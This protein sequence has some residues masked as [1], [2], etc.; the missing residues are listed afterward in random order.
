MTHLIVPIVDADTPLR[1]Q[2]AAAVASGADIVELRVDLIHDTAA[3]ETFLAERQASDPPLILTI[4]SAEEGGGWDGDDA[5]RLALFERLGLRMPGLIDIELATWQRSANLRQKAGLV[6]TRRDQPSGA[7]E[8]D[9]NDLVLSQ[10]DFAGT[11]DD[12]AA[13]LAALL[14]SPATIA[15]AA[16]TPVDATDAVR[17]LAALRDVAP[18]RSVILLGMGLAGVMTRVLGPKFGAWGVFAAQAADR[19]SAPG[20]PTIADMVGQYRFREVNPQTRVFGVIGWPVGHSR[21]PLI[22]NAAMQTLGIDGVYVPLPVRPTYAD[23]ARFLDC[24]SA[25]RWLDLDGVSVTIPHKEHALRWLRET[26]ATVSTL[27]ERCGAVN[28]LVRRDSGWFGENTDALGALDA[29]TAVVDR[30]LAK[31][32]VLV[33]GAGGVARGVVAALA[34]AGAAVTITNR[35][36]ERAAQLASELGGTTCA[37]SARLAAARSADLVV[38]ATS[39]GMTPAVDETPLPAEAL[40]SGQIVFETVYTPAE[41]RLARE[42]AAAGSLVIPGGEL[43]VRQAARQFSLW[44]DCEVDIELL[45]ATLR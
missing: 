28:T 26:G 41:T 1:Q 38:N 13:Q 20:Q 30:D 39:V 32:R 14:A 18:N 23:F 8:R 17:I 24:V 44:H 12:I 42:A 6:A 3:V 4:R 10:H 34:D 29:L 11:P 7:G 36:N 33:L 21:S 16:F 2:V 45:R 19:A 5:E 43:F 9:K 25:N 27:A 37:W 35:T 15:K 22:H 40:Q 31:L